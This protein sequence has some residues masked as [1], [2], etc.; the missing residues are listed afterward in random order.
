[1]DKI[2]VGD[3]VTIGTGT[4]HWIVEGITPGIAREGNEPKYSYYHLRSG[5]SGIKRTEVIGEDTV[6]LELHTKGTP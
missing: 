1:M 5:L 2:E 3:H 4:V 6:Q